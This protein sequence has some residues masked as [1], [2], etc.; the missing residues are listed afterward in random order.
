MCIRVCVLSKRGGDMGWG[1]AK[2]TR[3]KVAMHQKHKGIS[4]IKTKSNYMHMFPTI[5]EKTRLDATCS[6]Q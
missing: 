1:S 3:R 2:D 5:K 6:L 4:I